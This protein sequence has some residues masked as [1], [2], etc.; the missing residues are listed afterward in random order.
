M[1]T[2]DYRIFVNTSLGN[3]DLGTVNAPN[4]D[5]AIDVAMIDNPSIEV[6]GAMAIPCDSPLFKLPNVSYDSL[7]SFFGDNGERG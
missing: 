6:A 1:R 7:S 3:N 4:P 5:Q 2:K